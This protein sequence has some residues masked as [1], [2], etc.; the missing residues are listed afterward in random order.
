MYYETHQE[1]EI[2]DIK[3]RLR[4]TLATSTQANQV[5]VSL[6]QQ[7]EIE[8]ELKD[9]LSAKRNIAFAEQGTGRFGCSF[10]H[11]CNHWRRETGNS[12]SFLTD[13]SSDG[14]GGGVLWV[15]W[16]PAFERNVDESGAKTTRSVYNC[17]VGGIKVS[18][19]MNWKWH[20]HVVK[21]G[22]IGGV[23][24]VLYHNWFSHTIW[25]IR[26]RWQGLVDIATRTRWM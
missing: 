16:S 12:L 3:R 17:Y 11:C 15:M 6:N 25:N 4:V 19:L 13:A 20:I 1:E 8:K 10:F 24:D 22:H 23:C 26:T 21:E 18:L 9:L 2:N 5:L 7:V 14:D